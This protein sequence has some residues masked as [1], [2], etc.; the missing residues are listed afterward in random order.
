[1]KVRYL[2]RY[3]DSGDSFF[4]REHTGKAFKE[5]W[6]YHPELELAI[7]LE[8][9]GS[10]FIGDGIQ[11][12]EPGTMVLIG[13][14]LPH[15]WYN[16]KIY[17]DPESDRKVRSYTIHFNESF[18]EGLLQIPE[19]GEIKQLLMR[20]KRGIVF[21]GK[22]S[23]FIRRKVDEMVDAM[24]YERI[25]AFLDV[26]NCLS[27]HGQYVT[28]SSLVYVNSFRGIQDSKLVLVHEYIMNNFKEDISLSKI[29]DLARMNASS[30]SRYFSSV[31]KK[32]LTQFINEIR[33]G[34]ACKL[35]VAGEHNV[36]EACY[37]SGFK[38]LSN[39]NRHFLK[40][41][42]MQPSHY[43]KLHRRGLDRWGD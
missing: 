20:A 2:D 8:G 24:G 39:F 25:T 40:F 41:K 33:I 7:I 4:L 30:F 36:T 17:F 27:Q 6:H 10:V 35:I 16:D 13:K 29:A 14:N 34:Y 37:E 9:S 31:Q 18:A 5:L 32:T 3:V 28:L 26:L 21:P 15:I 12:F 43:L 23:S 19:L 11:N 22:P 1:M 38:N 42:K